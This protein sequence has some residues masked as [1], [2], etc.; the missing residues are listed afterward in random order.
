E[1]ERELKQ[2]MQALQGESGAAFQRARMSN[3][4]V[5]CDSLQRSI[6]LNDDVPALSSVHPARTLLLVGEPGADR[7]LTARVIV[8][9]LPR[10]GSSTGACV[11]MV[12]LHGGGCIVERLPFA[13][14]SLL[15]GDLPVNLLWASTIAPPL[16][17]VLMHELAE[18]AQQIIYDSIGWP[19]PIRGVLATAAWLEKIE[20]TGV[21]WRVASDLNWRRLKFWRRLLSQTLLAYQAAAPS[22]ASLCEIAIE[23]GPH[24]SIQA[25]LLASWLAD[26]LQATPQGGRVTPGVEMTW[27][28]RGP[29]GEMQVHIRRREQ[30]PATVQC[31]RLGCLPHPLIVSRESPQRLSVQHQHGDSTPRTVTVPA[32]SMADMIGRQLND[33][34][35]DRRFCQAMRTAQAMA[36]AVAGG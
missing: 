24:A 34:E 36:Q 5:F 28:F 13:V 22:D 12:T 15:I 18:P 31:V 9:P 27:Q 29:R 7:P 2:R 19:D 16:A 23:H 32:L 10:Q 21:R 30:G 11:E 25:W 20:R 35:R 3:L 1:I 33:R 26:S 8:R 14:R 6:E 17:G 4:I